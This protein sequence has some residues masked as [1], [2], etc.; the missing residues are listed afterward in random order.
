VPNFNTS[1]LSP[2]DFRAY[3]PWDVALD[4]CERE[5]S[6]YRGERQGR[7]R[8]LNCED[9]YNDLYVREKY[10]AGNWN[11]VPISQP[12]PT[13]GTPVRQQINP[14]IERL[15]TITK[16]L[17]E[18]K[19]AENHRR[20]QRAQEKQDREQ[21]QIE[22]TRWNLKEARRVKTQLYAR[23]DARRLANEYAKTEAYRQ[24]CIFRA[25][26]RAQDAANLQEIQDAQ[27]SD[28]W[29]QPKQ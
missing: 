2:R 7:Y 12:I 24:A 10:V 9:D 13:R 20:E 22:R 4:Q 16:D 29:T 23:E 28:T 5:D 17:Q 25:K 26:Q 11:E 6:D 21:R 18:R 19:E 8:Q 1:T 15:K 3:D 14:E 27:N